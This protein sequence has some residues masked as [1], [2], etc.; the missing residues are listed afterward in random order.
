MI[1]LASIRPW[2]TRRRVHPFAPPCHH[3]HHRGQI[4]SPGQGIPRAAPGCLSLSAQWASRSTLAQRHRLTVA[5][6]RR[7]IR[8]PLPQTAHRLM[9]G[10]FHGLV[11]PMCRPALRSPTRGVPVPGRCCRDPSLQT[12]APHW[13]QSQCCAGP[14][15]RAGRLTSSRRRDMAGQTAWRRRAPW[16]ARKGCIAATCRRKCEV[17]RMAMQIPRG[18][19]GRGGATD[20]MRL[21][22]R[23]AG[24]ETARADRA[25]PPRR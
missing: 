20:G 3:D 1:P 19:R 11:W 8:S 17:A 2:E 4:R 25:R 13:A 15:T 10:Q 23:I 21:C 22:G 5:E 7:K 14:G 12:A 24:R 18:Q 6:A 16:P 9:C